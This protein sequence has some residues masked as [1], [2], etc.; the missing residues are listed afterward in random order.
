[1]GN[2][3]VCAGP[4]DAISCASKN[5]YYASSRR[6]F[7]LSA[8]L[9]RNEENT[10]PGLEARKSGV[11]C[12]VSRDAVLEARDRTIAELRDQV[13]L[14]RDE[15][16]RRDAILARIAEGIG[17]LSPARI[18]ETAGVSQTITPGGVVWLEPTSNGHEGRTKPEKPALPSGYRVVA[19]ACDAWVLVAPRGL[20]VA[21]YRGELD[22]SK[23]ALDAREHH[24]RQ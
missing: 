18:P 21:G 6:C 8:M 3:L 1:M 22:L 16:K 12:E 7:T 2:S 14:L 15:L 17:E 9:Q 24:Q 4:D 10:A 13:A 20:R 19:T 5:S 11:S 23:V